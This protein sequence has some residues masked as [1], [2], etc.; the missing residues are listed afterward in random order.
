MVQVVGYLKEFL[1]KG[2]QYLVKLKSK[3]VTP[4]KIKTIML[5]YEKTSK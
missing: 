5:L 4:N 3:D 1:D 2:Q